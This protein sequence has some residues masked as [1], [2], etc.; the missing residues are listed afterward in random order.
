M[1]KRNEVAG[2]SSG[3]TGC[4]GVSKKRINSSNKLLRILDR[5]FTSNK[6]P[7]RAIIPEY[8]EF[9]PIS[10]GDLHPKI[11]PLRDPQP[12]QIFPF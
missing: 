10:F 8:S 5:N 9:Y 1:K 6:Y 12:W 7:L 4:T 2:N 3:F 11:Q